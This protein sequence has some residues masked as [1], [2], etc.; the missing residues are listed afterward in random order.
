MFK[1]QKVIFEKGAL[2]YELGKE[3][4]KRFKNENKE[5]IELAYNKI[6]SAI[7]GETIYEKYRSGKK[8]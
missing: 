8:C 7:E 5:I 3:L 4:Y 2:D 1:P 6:S